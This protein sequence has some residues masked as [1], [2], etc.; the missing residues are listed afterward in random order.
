MILLSP[1]SAGLEK[2]SK[3]AGT[4]TAWK[5][6]S[7]VFS[8]FISKDTL[9]KIQQGIN[10]NISLPANSLISLSVWINYSCQAILYHPNIAQRKPASQCAPLRKASVG[11]HHCQ[12]FRF[13]F[14][15]V[16]CFFETSCY[17][18]QPTLDFELS[19]LSLLSSGVTDATM[20]SSFQTLKR[21]VGFPC[22][23]IASMLFICCPQKER[24]PNSSDSRK[25]KGEKGDWTRER[26]VVN[27]KDS[28][29][30]EGG[31]ERR[32]ER[33]ERKKKRKKGIQ[34]HWWLISI[35]LATWEVK[36]SRK[37]V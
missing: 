7:T 27:E 2:M 20:P 11:S 17:V 30:K 18:A 35:I 16:F 9:Y 22:K 28:R 36:I 10:R 14:C 33:K 15:F 8:P 25:E 1:E 29:R 23:R 24:L 31:R 13:L 37:T 5:H 12:P 26:G 3:I 21:S 6:R 19:C 4:P 32:K 34:A